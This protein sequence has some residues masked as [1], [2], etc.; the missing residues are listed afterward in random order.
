M[1][2]TL[3]T[4]TLRAQTDLMTETFCYDR[5]DVQRLADAVRNLGVCQEKLAL[6]DKFILESKEVQPVI[7]T[8]I[9]TK[10]YLI[11]GMVVSFSVGS[12][13]GLYL[14]KVIK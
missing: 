10:N 2:L 12:L 9:Y 3:S 5:R 1:T 8:G 13:L 14:S 6:A 7:P 11:G 4:S